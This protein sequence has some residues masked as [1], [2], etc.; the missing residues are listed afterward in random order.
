MYFDWACGNK[1]FVLYNYDYTY[2]NY[3]GMWYGY[4][5]E[6]QFI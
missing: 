3:T 1:Y 4:G 2:N 5:A 6:D